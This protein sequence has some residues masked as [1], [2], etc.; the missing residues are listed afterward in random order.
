MDTT[1]LA[2]GLEPASSRWALRGRLNSG[3]RSVYNLWDAR[4]SKLA[5][6][7]FTSALLPGRDRRADGDSHKRKP[8]RRARG[9]LGRHTRR[10][11]DRVASV[12]SR[13]VDCRWR[14]PPE[15]FLRAVHL[16]DR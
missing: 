13:W 5:R 16:R 6:R 9:G 1:S 8:C 11:R 4:L 10:L 12:A 14:Y 2:S 7:E 15:K 3:C